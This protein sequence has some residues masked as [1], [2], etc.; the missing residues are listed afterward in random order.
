MHDSSPIVAGFEISHILVR[1]RL[2]TIVVRGAIEQTL[3][4]IAKTLRKEGFQETWSESIIL[5]NGMG[6][7]ID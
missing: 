7:L 5:R 1:C 2:S 3:S 4:T 6:L